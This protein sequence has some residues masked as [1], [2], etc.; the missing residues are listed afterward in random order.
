MEELSSVNFDDL[1]QSFP[2]CFQNTKDGDGSDVG[3]DTVDTELDMKFPDVQTEGLIKESETQTE[4]EIKESEVST[5][6]ELKEPEI[7][8]MDGLKESSIDG[9]IKVENIQREDEIKFSEEVIAGKVLTDSLENVEEMNIENLADGAKPVDGVQ[10]LDRSSGKEVIDESADAVFVRIDDT[11]AYSSIDERNDGF[12]EASDNV[13]II[14]MT[15]DV[16]VTIESMGPDDAQRN[17]NGDEKL[18]DKVKTKPAGHD[19][20]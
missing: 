12:D 1:V 5:E 6:D 10:D 13:D 14:D 20:F 8:I 3:D 19:E 11:E 18:S 15:P 17:G 9:K 7:Q 16:S 2:Q 4:Y